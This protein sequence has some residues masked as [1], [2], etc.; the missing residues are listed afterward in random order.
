[1]PAPITIR[2]P[3]QLLVEGKSPELFIGAMLPS[4]GLSDIQIH[5]F[6]GIGDLR[7][8]LKLLKNDPGF[9]TQ[10]MALG[11]IRDAEG[12]SS[13][14]HQS[15]CSALKAAG[16]PEP[17]KPLFSCGGK[18]RVSAFFFPDCASPGMLED[19]CLQ[20]VAKDPAINCVDDYF[21]CLRK[22]SVASPTPLAKARLQAFLAS[23]SRPNLQLGQAAAASYFPWQDPA[24]D[25]LKHFLHT[26]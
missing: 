14:A 25:L 8:F 20:A 6:G 19:L 10:V 5:D 22:Q 24:F 9:G 2:A 21:D 16:L 7:T 23:R 18:P 4:I 15:V 11:I 1:M 26:F 12:S 3:R 17:P 13:S